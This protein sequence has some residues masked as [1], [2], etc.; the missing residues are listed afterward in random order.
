[1]SSITSA[2]IK[3][4]PQTKWGPWLAI[5]SPF[6]SSCPSICTLLKL[7]RHPSGFPTDGLSG[8]CPTR[9]QLPRSRP[10][11]QL[12][13]RLP[14]HLGEKTVL[15][16]NK[17]ISTQTHM[18]TQQ[19][20]HLSAFPFN[21]QINI[22]CCQSPGPCIIYTQYLMGLTFQG[23]HRKTGAAGIWLK[24]KSWNSSRCMVLEGT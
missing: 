8:C 14:I 18:L 20:Q 4:Q 9:Q 11:C 23:V 5:S 17:I 21:C 22:C 16:N 1:M 19:W 3:E 2:T 6:N 7:Q 13:T 24:I 12:R 10:L 15:S